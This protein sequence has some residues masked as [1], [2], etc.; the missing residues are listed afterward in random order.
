MKRLLNATGSLLGLLILIALGIGLIVLFRAQPTGSR[1]SPLASPTLLSAAQSPLSTPTPR[2]TSTRPPA[3]PTRTPRPTFTPAPPTETPEPLPTLV[4]GW[5][6]FV[7]AT[8]KDGRPELYRFQVDST[9]HKAGAAY[10]IDTGAWPTSRTRIE[11]LYPSPDGKHVA[12]AWVYG[13]GG[14]FISILDVKTGRLTPLFGEETKIDQ[15]AFFLDWSRDGNSLLVL[16]GVDNHDL[17]GSAW[18]VDIYDHSYTSVPIKQANDDAREITSASF[19]PDGKAIVYARAMCYQCG[20]EVRRVDLGKSDQQLLLK[21]PEFRVEDISW[22]TD[23]RYIAFT[24]WRQTAES[25]NFSTGELWLM[26]TNGG[27]KHLLSPALTGYAKQFTPVWSPTSAQI[28][29]VNNDEI[30]LSGPLDKFHTNIYV[31]DITSGRVKQL[32]Q[33]DGTLTLA[34]A[35]S[36]EGSALAFMSNLDGP[37]GQLEFWAIQTGDQTAHRIDETGGLA[38]TLNTSNV[39]FVWLP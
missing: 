14:T 8:T 21:V 2:P 15:R 11:D 13:E 34:P 25:G 26:E 35:W 24:Q 39:A 19:S 1:V 38:V 18:M 29:F 30:T 5:Q 12:V 27:N 10:R 7:Y 16:G 33:F 37:P 6:T 32:T 23:G 36:P 17:G 20:S 22:S 4:P 9:A 3:L 31:I 28:A